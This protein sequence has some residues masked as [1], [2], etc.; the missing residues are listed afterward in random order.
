MGTRLTDAGSI[1][2]PED[3]FWLEWMEVRDA[4]Q[5]SGD[6]RALVAKRKEEASRLGRSEAPLTIGPTLPPDAPRIYLVPEI[7]RLLN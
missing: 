3:I 7:L 6:R 4:L 2:D 1:N 5:N